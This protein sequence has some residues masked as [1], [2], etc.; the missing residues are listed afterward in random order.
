MAFAEEVCLFAW[1]DA[2]QINGRVMRETNRGSNG[3]AQMRSE[4]E[5]RAVSRGRK[6]VCGCVTENQRPNAKTQLT[7]LDTE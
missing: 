1:F 2:R 5:D 4:V 7:I 3:L 6:I